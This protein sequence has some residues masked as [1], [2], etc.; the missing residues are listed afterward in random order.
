M[1]DQTL[2]EIG[3][4]L[5]VGAGSTLIGKS[6]YR[7][8]SKGKQLPGCLW[9]LVFVVSSAVVFVSLSVTR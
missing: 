6:V 2:F 5:I 4:S 3:G 1:V 7:R 9:V 8:T